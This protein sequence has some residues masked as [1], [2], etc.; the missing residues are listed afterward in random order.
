MDTSN[1]I[2]TTFEVFVR[3]RKSVKYRVSNLI[4]TNAIINY[5]AYNIKKVFLYDIFVP[6]IVFRDV[7][8]YLVF[9]K[10]MPCKLQDVCV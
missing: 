2:C 8:I 4:I 10:N 6:R 9:N 3:T 1:F 7:L 5:G